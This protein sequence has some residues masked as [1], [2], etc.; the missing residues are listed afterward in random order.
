MF[1]EL[2]SVTQLQ[3]K[4]RVFAKAL[5][6][7]TGTTLKEIKLIVNL[8]IIEELTSVVPVDPMDMSNA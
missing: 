1:T 6:R 3:I 4:V 2:A 5:L 7:V 8:V